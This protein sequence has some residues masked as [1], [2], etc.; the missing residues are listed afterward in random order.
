MTC[1]QNLFKT[2]LLPVLY[3][4]KNICVN[5]KARPHKFPCGDIKWS[6]TLYMPQCTLAR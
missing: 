5:N 3:I 2:I 1:Y 6:Y 4:G